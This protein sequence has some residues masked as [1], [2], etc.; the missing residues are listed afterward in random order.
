MKNIFVCRHCLKFLL[1]TLLILPGLAGATEVFQYSK[2]DL[3]LGFRKYSPAGSYELVVN[4][5]SVTNYLAMSPGATVNISQF[6]SDELSRSFATNYNKLKWSVAGT[7]YPLGTPWNGFPYETLWYTL[8][9]ASADTQTSAPSRQSGSSQS[10]PMQSINS[11]GSDA[12]LL[13]G[14]TTNMDNTPSLVREPAGDADAYSTFVKS[15][16][17]PSMGNYGNWTYNVENTTP[18]SF[19]SPVVSDLYQ[20]VPTGSTD[21]NT[22]TNN[23]AAYYVGYFTLNA[24]GTM[25]F[26]RASLVTP[27]PPAPKIVKVT[28]VGTTST[29]FFTTTNASFTYTLYYTNSAGLS[30]STSNWPASPTTFFPGNGLTNSLTD[31]TTATNRFYRVGVQ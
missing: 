6:S 13:S 20:S 25:T 2:G 21:P 7:I 24:D 11:I 31:T 15:S 27:Q 3:V 29:I 17:D 14:D 30:S 28:R 19:T 22:G 1:L 5:G 12:K 4:A 16:T 8:P 18:S 26:T 10:S 9:R 23:G